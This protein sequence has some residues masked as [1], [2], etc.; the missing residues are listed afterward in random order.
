MTQKI[1]ITGYH[2]GGEF[3]MGSIEKELYDKLKVSDDMYET[4]QEEE[5][6]WFEV[7]DIVH[8]YG[9]FAEEIYAEIDDEEQEIPIQIIGSREQGTMLEHSH[10]D[11]TEWKRPEHL[12]LACI[13]EEKGGFQF[14]EI[15]DDNFDEKEVFVTTIETYFGEFIED[16]IY[17]GEILEA[18][19]DDSSTN[20]KAF[21]MEVGAID[22]SWLDREFTEEDI[23]EMIEEYKHFYA[24]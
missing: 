7:D 14:W 6:E 18:N 17:K 22:K 16:V 20:G 24:S 8:I 13:S 3:T 19:Y 11:K 12:V 21:S 4:L 23:E 5:I 1:K 10:I 9:C 2:W 15:E